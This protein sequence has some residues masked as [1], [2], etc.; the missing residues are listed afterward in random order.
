MSDRP[1][2]SET[3]AFLDDSFL[4][5]LER[6][7]LMAKKG[8]KGPQRGEHKAWQSGEGL[9]FLDYR[10]Y[11][12]G[13]DLRYVDWSVYG[14]LDKL[15][16]KLFH[17][18]ENQTIHILVDMSRSMGAAAAAKALNAKRIAAAM[19]YVAL[20]NLD[21][22]TLT[23][24]SET[25]LDRRAPV[26][27]KRKYPD[28]LRFLLALW[29]DAPTNLNA[30]LSEY[31]A[32]G[33]YPGIVLI[34]SDLFDPNGYQEGLKTLMYKGYDV[35]LIQILDHAELI[36]PAPGTLLL[37]DVETGAQKTT[38]LD[39]EL[40]ERYQ[41]KMGA[42][43]DEIRAFCHTYG[44]HHYVYDTRIPFETFLIDYLRQGAMFR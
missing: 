44:L 43:L 8:L 36:G 15:F 35:H 18:E 33:R 14:R 9:E 16:I 37:R 20:S 13:D 1:N 34:L 2:T 19:S 24:F 4:N 29:P 10:K 40:V 25:L 22:V 23:A 3:A 27:G 12:A 32:I 28:I 7:K 5:H 6:L 42:F 38:L 31:A 26:R 39:A 17:A 11:Q 21:K 30:C 41:H